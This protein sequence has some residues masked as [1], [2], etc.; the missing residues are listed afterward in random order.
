M[1]LAESRRLERLVRDLLDLARLDARAFS[2]DPRPST[3][4]T[5]AAGAVDGFRP[6]ARPSASAAHRR[7]APH[8]AV[9]VRPTPTG[10]RRWSPTSSRTPRSSP[11]STVVVGVGAERR[12]AELAVDD[13]GPGIAAEDLPH[14]FERLYVSAHRPSRSEIGSGLGL[15]IVQRAGRR[16]WAARS[17][18]RAR[19]ERRRPPASCDLP[20]TAA[21]ADPVRRSQ[22]RDVPE[23]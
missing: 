22:A 15:A 20:L 10:S 3:S 11:A 5:S 4:A 18:R 2:L 1:I 6:D 23:P 17:R 16:R 14:V 19:A 7:R 21:D 9:V 13:D 12:R 8:R